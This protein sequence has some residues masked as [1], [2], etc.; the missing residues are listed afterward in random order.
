[1]LALP[2]GAVLLLGLLPVEDRKLVLYEAG[3]ELPP[4]FTADA[5]AW[6][7]E[8]LRPERAPPAE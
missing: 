7:I 2:A 5:A 6:L 8:R 3:H 1:M 4:D